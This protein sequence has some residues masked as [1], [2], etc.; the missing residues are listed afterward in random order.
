MIDILV[1]GCGP[2]GITAA[3]KA[4]NKHNRVV[5]LERNSQPLKKLLMTGNGKCNYMN[6]KYSSSHY[7]SEDIEIVE[8]I[9]KV[10]NIEKMKSFFNILGIVPK[11][12]DGYYYP[13]SKQAVT[14][15]NALVRKAL[16]LG[17][18]IIY[19]TKVLDIKKNLTSFTVTCD[20][21]T[22]KTKKVV[23]ATGGK[24]YPNTG[25]DGGGY[26]LLSKLGHTIVEPYPAL[27]Q[28]I[29][30]F[31]YLKDWDGI[32]SDVEI[33]V[34]ED[35]RYLNRERGEI[36]LTDYG[37]SG[38]CVFNI[39]N[40]I[41]R[42]IKDHEIVLKINFVPFIE[43]LVTLWMDEYSKKNPKLS[44]SSLLE[45][46]LNYKLVKVIL[47][48]CKI[49]GKSCYQDLSKEDKFIICKNL[50]AFPI[51]IT[52]SK[53]FD[54]AQVTNG[55]VKLNEINPSTM[56]STIVKGL[57]ITGE[58]LDMNGNCG[59]YNLSVCWISGILA[60]EHLYDKS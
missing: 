55:G 4:K 27:T 24:S 10:K 7:V 14:I 48:T 5:I 40:L 36:Q 20:N 6:E 43:T 25:S 57:Y 58:L 46:F 37:V 42:K 47:K 51:I 15:K 54:S 23:L 59:G 8:D 38:V 35:G 32:R 9:L 1:I 45:G 52:D 53:S 18:E 30:S 21:Q 22:Y 39:S 19:D 13:F 11:I 56:E 33:E 34:F 17:I 49:D 41:T 60:G 26:V 50:R 12:K 3:I 28:L 2:S 44:L 29:S 16:N 31:P